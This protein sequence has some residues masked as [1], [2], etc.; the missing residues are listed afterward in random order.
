[1][2]FPTYLE[3][4]FIGMFFIK[5]VSNRIGLFGA[6]FGDRIYLIVFLGMIGLAMLYLVFRIWRDRRMEKKRKSID[7]DN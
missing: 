6:I 2:V 4:T 3:T 1:M 7:K 5:Q